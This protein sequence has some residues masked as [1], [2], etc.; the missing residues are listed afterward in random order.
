M[1]SSPEP[2]PSLAKTQLMTELPSTAETS[3]SPLPAE[4]RDE[5]GGLLGRAFLDDPASLFIFTDAARRAAHLGWLYP[6]IVHL[7]HPFGH[8][9][10]LALPNAALVAVSSWIPPGG[11]V[12]VRAILRH[13]LLKAPLVLGWG[14]VKRMLSIFEYFERER[15]RLTEGKPHWYLDQL[16]VEPEHQGRGHGRRALTLALERC[17]AG[18]KLPS[19][20]FTSKA[21]NVPFYQGSGFKVMS[22][23]DFGSGP[24]RYRSWAMMRRP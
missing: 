9:C 10:R 11:N 23:R 18:E 1:T 24:T 17:E 22:E 15:T 12:G 16:A 8:T 6:R 21:R 3:F 13:G 4:Q 7:N 19:L 20:L 2:D 5:A 14:S